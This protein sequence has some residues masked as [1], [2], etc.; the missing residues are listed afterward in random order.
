M[1]QVTTE[2]AKIRLLDLIDE[3]IKGETVLIKEDENRVV[4]LVPVA[5]SKGHRQFGSARG[6]IHMS[7][8]F[9]EPLEDFKEYME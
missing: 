7:D 9:D 4:L 5:Q 6:M 1:V 2:E 8:D 3:A